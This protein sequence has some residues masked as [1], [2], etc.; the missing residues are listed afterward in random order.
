MSH[1]ICP[2]RIHGQKIASLTIAGECYYSE[3]FM[4]CLEKRCPVFRVDCGDAYCYR[5][6]NPIKL[7]EIKET[8]NE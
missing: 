8:E 5:N 3:H 6:N 2:F 4:P 1:F 7:G